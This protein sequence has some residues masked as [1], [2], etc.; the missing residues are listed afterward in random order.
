[1]QREP[2]FNAPAIV[3]ALAALFIAVQ[4][5][6]AYLP[7]DTSDLWF[8]SLSLVPARLGPEAGA[9]P[10][11]PLAAW[12]SLLTHVFVHADW[13]HL[14]MNTA[15]LLV[16]GSIMARRVGAVRMLLLFLAASLAGA[17]LYMLMHPLQLGTL[18]G[19]SGGLSGLMGGVFRFLFQAIDEGQG[20]GSNEPITIALPSL[21][22]ALADQRVRMS[23]GAWLAINLLFGLLPAGSITDGIIAWEAHLGGFLLGFLAMALFDRRPAS[24]SGERGGAV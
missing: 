2:I 13:G 14:I 19:A 4:A 11:W 3:V 17:G 5:L 15:W 23:V 8:I 22:E 18:V 12:T 24:A 10:G 21:G 1:M 16:F 6:L 20:V 7:Q 9:V